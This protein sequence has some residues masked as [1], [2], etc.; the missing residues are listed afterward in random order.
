MV[1]LTFVYQV[2]CGICL[3]I[4]Q[5]QFDKNDIKKKRSHA[6]ELKGCLG[7]KVASSELPYFG[8]I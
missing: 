8:E 7:Q 6:A 5:E 3:E 1:N 4:F 2:P